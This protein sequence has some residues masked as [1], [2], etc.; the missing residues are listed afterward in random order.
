MISY[1]FFSYLVLL[2]IMN[3]YQSQLRRYINENIYKKPIFEFE[4]FGKKYWWIEKQ[5]KKF[6]I[7]F[8]WFQIL[9]IKIPQNISDKE[10]FSEIKK[11]KQSFSKWNHIF[12][13]LWIINQLD[14]P[15]FENRKTTQQ[16]LHQFGL[17]P[18]IKENMPL[19]TIEVDLTKPEE[20]LYSSFS[21]NS[22]FLSSSSPTIKTFL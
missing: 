2:R 4:L 10:I 5:H 13:Q 6:W 12:F 9:G 14:E 8:Y 1:E 21:K 20:T 22:P 17:Y 15:F 3:F 7:P 18:S 19:A 16:Y 11:I